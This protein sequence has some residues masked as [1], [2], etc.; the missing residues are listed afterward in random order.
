MTGPIV[1]ITPHEL[2]INDP[3][4][5]DD[6]FSFK[7][8][9]DRYAG[10]TQYF[11]MDD[12]TVFTVPYDKHRLR[13]GALAPF[14]GRNMFLTSSYANIIQGKVE[15]LCSRIEKH[16]ETKQ[17]MNLGLAFRCLATDVITDYALG[18]SYDL[19]DAPDFNAAWFEAQRGASEI[20]LLCKHFPWLMP[21]LR[22]L[23]SWLATLLSP[24]M[25]KSLARGKVGCLLFKIDALLTGSWCRLLKPKSSKS[26]VNRI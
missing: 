14:F 4:F 1:R 3:S 7:S 16:R 22:Y 2:H 8:K 9:L 24:E 25:G 11:G 20:V 6:I 23:P 15:K 10:A 13:R 5:T 21:L 12:A 17:P 19:L 26:V 18:D